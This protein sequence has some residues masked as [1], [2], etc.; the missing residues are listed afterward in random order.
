MLNVARFSVLILAL[1]AGG[2][3]VKPAIPLPLF[4][5]T[6]KDNTLTVPDQQFSE[7]EQS[8]AIVVG[9]AFYAQL[10]SCRIIQR[11][12][13]RTNQ[14]FVSSMNLLKNR[15]YMM[16][17]KWITIV[18]HTEIDRIENSFQSGPDTVIL[19]DGTDLGSS[20]YLTILAADLYDCPCSASSCGGR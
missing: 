6:Y 11:Y 7:T 17:S 5:Y 8:K 12:Q 18:K 16:G 19:R 15:A 14:D 4:S 10:N 2:C 13:V 3:A 20:R 1:I 9:S